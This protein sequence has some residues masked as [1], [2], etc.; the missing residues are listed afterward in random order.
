M[1][2]RFPRF[3]V[4]LALLFGVLTLSA[5]GKGD[6]KDKEKP[7]EPVEK[8]YN[9]AMGK[10]NNKEY[11]D[12]VKAFEEVERQHPYSE[13]AVK[14]EIMAAYANY[15]NGQ[16]DSAVSSLDRFVKQHPGNRDT[17]YA[18]YLKALCYYE[19]ITDVGRDQ[20]ITS[21]AQQALNEVVS[22]FPDSEYA[23]DA[24]FKLDLVADHLAGKEMEIGRYYER[25]LEFLAAI[26][27]FRVVVEKYQTTSHTPEALHRLVECY[28][29][30]GVVDQ[31]RHY[32][33]VLGFNYPNSHWYKDSFAL[34]N[35]KPLPPVESDEKK[36]WWQKVNPF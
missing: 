10:L 19:Q 28:L 7:P 12:A 15:R 33:S 23:R 26:N 1:S 9:D 29:R 31:A 36:S 17:P 24:H 13:W 32:A 5:C 8:L 27:R 34:M 22:R 25:H 4:F 11:K 14:S 2:R 35:G 6:D 21:Q 3:L 30:L 18:Y 16:Y 20:K